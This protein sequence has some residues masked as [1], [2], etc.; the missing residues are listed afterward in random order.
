MSEFTIWFT[1]IL[2][3]LLAAAIIY[4]IKESRGNQKDEIS[5]LKRI[6]RVANE[7]AEKLAGILHQIYTY[8]IETSEEIRKLRRA[9]VRTALLIKRRREEVGELRKLTNGAHSRLETHYE[10]IYK[11]LK[12]ADDLT[13]RINNIGNESITIKIGEQHY[14][15][16]GKKKK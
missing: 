4:F 6:R 10:F 14:I 2:N 1:T 11:S 12:R 7:N 15:V 13:K 5:D 8:K 9:V 16:K 3:G